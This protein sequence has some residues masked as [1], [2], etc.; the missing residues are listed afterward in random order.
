MKGHTSYK[1]NDFP[2]W[3]IKVCLM[4]SVCLYFFSGILCLMTGDIS[5]IGY[6]RFIQREI[7]KIAPSF[8]V[9]G[10]ICG[11]IVDLYIKDTEK[12]KR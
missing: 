6:F 1:L 8:L 9:V 7:L 3:L 12:E 4:A 5:E 11:V 2:I 10:V